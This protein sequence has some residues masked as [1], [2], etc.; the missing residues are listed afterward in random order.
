MLVSYVS[1]NH[2]LWDEVLPKIACA[3]RTARHEVIGLT[4]Y[5]VNFG[6]E[7]ILSGTDHKGQ[8]RENEPVNLDRGKSDVF[9]HRSEALRR[10]Y[11]DI[12]LRLQQSYEKSKCR[13]DLRRRAVEYLPN[14][15]VWRKNFVL[16]DAAK[17]FSAKLADKYIGPFMI[18]RRIGKDSYELKDLDEKVLRGTWHTSHLKPQVD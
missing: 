18:H 13:Y 9:A 15:L 3:V 16:S 2:R 5:F 12:R 10:V 7:M 14:Q 1:T 4:P 6:R 11:K 8:D 17:Y